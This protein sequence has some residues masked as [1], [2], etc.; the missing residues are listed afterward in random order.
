[1]TPIQALEQGFRV[2]VPNERLARYWLE[3]LAQKKTFVLAQPIMSWNQ[4]ISVLFEKYCFDEAVLCLSDRDAALWIWYLFY[5]TAEVTPCPKTFF[6]SYQRLKRWKHGEYDL[7]LYPKNY[8]QERF[9]KFY[10]VVEEQKKRE[11]LFFFE[12]QIT[13]LIQRLSQRHS[14]EHQK[15]YL[16]GFDDLYPLAQALIE[17]H[18]IHHR[19]D[20]QASF[21]TQNLDSLQTAEK[22]FF[23][24]ERD[25]W[26][27]ALIWLKNRPAHER[28][29]IIVPDLDRRFDQTV[30]KALSIFDP[31][32]L[33]T[34]LSQQSEKISFSH[35]CSLDQEPLIHTWYCAIAQQEYS[36]K[37]LFWSQWVEFWLHLAKNQGMFCDWTLSSREYQAI[38]FLKKHLQDSLHLSS[39]FGL[40]NHSIALALL[41]QLLE[42]LVFQPQSL[43]SQKMILGL[44]E[45]V[46]LPWDAVWMIDCDHTRFPQSLELDP[47]VPF[48]LQEK[49]HYPHSSLKKEQEYLTKILLRLSQNSQNILLSFHESVHHLPSFIINHVFHGDYQ[50]W[51]FDSHQITKKVLGFLPSPFFQSPSSLSVSVIDAF[52]QCPFSGFVRSLN[53]LKSYCAND[54]HPYFDPRYYGDLVHRLI[55]DQLNPQAWIQRDWVL[56]EFWIESHRKHWRDLLESSA[57]EKRSYAIEQ[58]FHYREAGGWILTGRLDLYDEERSRIIDIKTTFHSLG[59]WIRE[60]PKS[61][62]GPIYALAKNASFL[63][64]L[65]VDKDRLVYQENAVG[66][67]IAT[68]REHLGRLLARWEYGDYEP[69]P[70]DLSVCR[71]CA[72]K[73]SCRYHMIRLEG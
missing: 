64:I 36:G 15:I 28:S 54:V 17:A 66:E 22:Y 31:L 65:S 6:K 44:L 7:S 35:G 68:W 55:Q 42:S 12:D 58:S 60:C 47:L 16:Y 5:Q 52:S 26:D 9:L 62:Q 50:R 1:M 20:Q 39:L 29:A 63:G 40:L 46:A 56:P 49:A 13:L 41:N 21:S 30:K 4:W 70:S 48:D 45:A 72:F 73:S 33:C 32:L 38:E 18:A 8:S 19:V 24:Q 61:W 53:A 10:R 2:I 37:S 43:Q 57:L 71:T 3:V 11:K 51:L 67:H 14:P 27:Q 34:S 25:Q 23:S 69:L 59:E